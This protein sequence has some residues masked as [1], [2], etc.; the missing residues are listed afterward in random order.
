VNV[1]GVVPA[2]SGSKG[3]PDKNL[4]TLAGKPLL[5]YVAKAVEEANVID[6]LV[7]TT[8]SESIAQ[9]GRDYGFE[10]PFLRPASLAADDTPMLDTVQHAVEELEIAGWRADIIVLLQPTSPLRKAKHIADAVGALVEDRADSIASV[11]AIPDKFSPQKAMKVE[12]GRLRFWSEQGSK[13]TRRQQLQPTYVREGTVYACLYDVLMNMNT[14]YGP[15]CIP[16]PLDPEESLSLDTME[17]WQ[18]A[19][20]ILSA[21]GRLQ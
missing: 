15:K 4:R 13:I 14:L 18:R 3:I 8:D 9:L 19:E 2:R 7:L 20:S 17:D 12:D 10:V 5:A 16:L 6:R 21:Q 11:V 1:L